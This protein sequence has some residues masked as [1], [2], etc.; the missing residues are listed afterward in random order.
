MMERLNIMIISSTRQYQVCVALK[1]HWKYS[2][3]LCSTRCVSQRVMLPTCPRGTSWI[4]GC[5]WIQ[6]WKW[7]HR[8]IGGSANTAEAVVLVVK[9][10]ENVEDEEFFSNPPLCWSSWFPAERPI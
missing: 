8:W 2:T 5:D 6:K 4:F 7:S 1:R 10:E 3:S 9:E